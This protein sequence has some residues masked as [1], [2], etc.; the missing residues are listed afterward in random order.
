MV[1]HALIRTQQNSLLTAGDMF[2]Q[3]GSVHIALTS[4]ALITFSLP[5]IIQIHYSNTPGMDGCTA[6]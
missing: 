5:N 1:W 4:I 2:L 3:P 6:R